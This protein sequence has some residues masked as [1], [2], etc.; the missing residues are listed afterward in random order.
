MKK[1]VCEL[2]KEFKPL[3]P[4]QLQ[5]LFKPEG[6]IVVILWVVLCLLAYA[7]YANN[8]YSPTITVWIVATLGAVFV[9]LAFYG[10]AVRLIDNKR[11]ADICHENGYT[12]EEWNRCG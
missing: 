3:F 6:R 2:R 8:Y 4:S 1:T 9:L 7:S 10:Y 5:W 12:T 11:I